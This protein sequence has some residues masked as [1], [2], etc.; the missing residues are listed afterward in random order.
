MEIVYESQILA[1]ELVVDIFYMAMN[2][3][4][5]NDISTREIMRFMGVK[6]LDKKRNTLYDLNAI[7]NYDENDTR[8]KIANYTENIV[9]QY[10]KQ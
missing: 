10:L 5:V 2:E 4:G 3:P 8:N 9:Q 7:R 1:S 6:L